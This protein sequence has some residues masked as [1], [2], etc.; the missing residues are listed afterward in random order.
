M[1]GNVGKAIINSAVEAVA[2]LFQVILL[3]FTNTITSWVVFVV[4]REVMFIVEQ[5]TVSCMGNIFMLIFVYRKFNIWKPMIAEDILI[6]ILDYWE[7]Q[8]F[9][10]SV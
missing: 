8:V 3:L 2:N 10:L 7:R 6:P 5:D 4:L 9:L 1:D